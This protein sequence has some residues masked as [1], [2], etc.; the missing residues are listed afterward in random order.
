MN[1]KELR[2]FWIEELKK[3][4]MPSQIKVKEALLKNSF[5]QN[6]DNVFAY[7]PFKTE[8]NIRSFVDEIIKTKKVFLPICFKERQLAFCQIDQNW[9][10]NLERSGNKTLVPINK[11][12]TPLKEIKGTTIIL[13][14]GL[15]FNLKKYRLG[16][17]GGYYDTLLEKLKD[18]KNYFSIGLCTRKQ[19]ISNLNPD[20][21]DR[22]MDDLII[23]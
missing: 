20:A 15:A 8:I 16:R 4:Q 3:T 18:D 23:I 6:A 7:V 21:F 9:K 5:L 17:G 2:K 22:P 1:K 14:P 12:I 13:I 11:A 10:D 19:I